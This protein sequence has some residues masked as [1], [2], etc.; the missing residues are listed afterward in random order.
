MSTPQVGWSHPYAAPIQSIMTDHPQ[1][2][3]RY[4][5]DFS[6]CDHAT[7][8]GSVV[9]TMTGSRPRDFLLCNQAAGYAQTP[10]GYTWHHKYMTPRMVD[11]RCDMQLVET[12]AHRRSCCHLGGFGQYVSE[13]IARS[14]IAGHLSSDDETKD[15][16]FQQSK[17]AS[18]DLKEQAAPAISASD[19]EQTIQRL[20]LVLPAPLEDFYRSGHKL[21]PSVPF[22]EAVGCTY[23]VSNLYP[24]AQSRNTAE[25]VEGIMADEAQRPGG[26]LL[27]ARSGAIPL[28][29]DPFGNIYFLSPEEDTVYFYDHETDKAFSTYIPLQIF[30]EQLSI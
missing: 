3:F 13:E 24:L 28:A 25:T 18:T 23:L 7:Y 10:Q 17:L 20:G 26:P 12:G 16:L 27:F 2:R 22:L 1:E 6:A 15:R 30:L 5:P 9:I 29:D 14:L 21:T 11:N 19:L 4:S 8:L